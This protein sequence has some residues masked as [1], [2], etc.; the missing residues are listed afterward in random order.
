MK[1]E[2][3]LFAVGQ[4]DDKLVV[5]DQ[6]SVAIDRRLS[7][8]AD[9]SNGGLGDR[10]FPAVPE[11]ATNA[12][13]EGIVGPG[14][15]QR[16]AADGDFQVGEGDLEVAEFEIF[17]N[18]DLGSVAADVPRGID[19]LKRQ[20]VSIGRQHRCV[21]FAQ[22][23]GFDRAKGV[24]D[25]RCRNTGFV[26]GDRQT[27]AKVFRQVV[28]DGAEDVLDA[29]QLR[30]AGYIKTDR[31]RSIVERIDDGQRHRI[32]DAHVAG[33]V[34]GGAAE[35]QY[36][37]Q[38]F[39]DRQL[40]PAAGIEVQSSIQG[41]RHS[42]AG[43]A[44]E[45][46]RSGHHADVVGGEQFERDL[47][48]DLRSRVGREDLCRRAGGVGGDGDCEIFSRRFSPVA[49][50]DGD[51]NRRRGDIIDIGRPRDPAVGVDRDAGIGRFGIQ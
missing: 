10:R 34:S 51:R 47:V 9:Q 26:A 29:G 22:Q 46:Q 5:G 28:G 25:D 16:D 13:V 1:D 15:R 11:V 49:G 8:R 41:S 38:G 50:G 43:D 23:P 31:R 3:F 35:G 6:R 33:R 27:P 19:T 14:D 42:T 32:S 30:A 40:G 18:F 4:R 20:G 2:R 24:G 17:G 12:G 39:V 21:D 7:V 37:D 48:A 36:A 45:R 44:G